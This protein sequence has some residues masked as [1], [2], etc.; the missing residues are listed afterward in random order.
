MDMTADSVWLD[1]LASVR[2]ISHEPDGPVKAIIKFRDGVERQASIIVA[3]RVL[4]IAGPFGFTQKLDLAS[5]TK[6]DFD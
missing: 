3:N 6:I 1:G 5:L 4:Y 2:E